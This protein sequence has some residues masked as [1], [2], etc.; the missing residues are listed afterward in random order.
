[1]SSP[2]KHHLDKRALDLIEAANAG[3]DDAL[4]STPVTA[5]WLGVSDQWLE[6]GR[7]HGWGPP[8]I[9]LSPRRIRYRVGDVKEWLRERAHRST[10]EYTAPRVCATLNKNGS[11]V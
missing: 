10:A 8:F 6:I 4:L 2:Q 9:R 3:A 1:M 11:P 5:G 7:H